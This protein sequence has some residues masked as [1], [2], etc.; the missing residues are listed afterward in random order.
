M[1]KQVNTGIIK[2]VTPN[3]D[4]ISLCHFFPFQE[5]IAEAILSNKIPEAQI[6][7]QIHQHP[8]QNFPE[9]IQTGLNLVYDCL[10][11]NDTREASELLRNMVRGIQ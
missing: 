11:K 9:L 6:F 10:L 2:V 5:V 8:A 1:G 3:I 4:G 7:F